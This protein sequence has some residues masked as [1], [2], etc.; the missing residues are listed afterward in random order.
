AMELEPTLFGII[1]ALAPQLL[2]QSHLQTFVSDVVNLLRSSTK[3]A[4]QLGPLI[5]FYKLQSL[6]SPETTIMWHK[7][8]KFLDALFGIQ[9]TDDMVKYLSVFQ[10]L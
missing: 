2:S 5:D 3:S 8:E 9:N 7:I 1:E 4:T 6:D 10:S